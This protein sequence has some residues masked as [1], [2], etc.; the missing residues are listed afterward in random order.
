MRARLLAFLPGLRAADAL[1]Q[2][3]P[4]HGRVFQIGKADALHRRFLMTDGVFRLAAPVIGGGNPEPQGKRGRLVFIVNELLAGRRQK[5]VHSGLVDSGL[6]VIA[7]ALNGPKI[8]FHSLGNKVN[9]RILAAEVL[10]VRKF[11]PEPD[12]PERARIPRHRLQK[13]LH[14]PLETVALVA[15]GKGNSAVSGKN[16]LKGHGDS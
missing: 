2:R 7:L 15:F 16:I 4:V 1:F 5:T 8:A 12:M 3:G 6:F 11:P 10:L 13:S 9:A 14:E